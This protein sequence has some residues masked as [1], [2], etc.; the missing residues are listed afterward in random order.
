MSPTRPTTPFSGIHLWR[1]LIH[2]SL[3]VASPTRPKTN[4]F[5]CP[6]VVGYRR[7]RRVRRGQQP[8]RVSSGGRTITMS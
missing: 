1:S 2:Q 3:A 5:R 6:H 8:W 4:L 7:L